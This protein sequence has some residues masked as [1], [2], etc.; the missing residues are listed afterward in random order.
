M[1]IVD[2]QSS[3]NRFTIIKLNPH[4]TAQEMILVG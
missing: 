4:L 1:T 3:D 2:S